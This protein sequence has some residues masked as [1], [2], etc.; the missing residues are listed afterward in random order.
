MNRFFYSLDNDELLYTKE[1]LEDVITQEDVSFVVNCNIND[2]KILE[3][4]EAFNKKIKGKASVAVLAINHEEDYIEDETQIERLIEIDDYCKQTN[5]KLRVHLKD[6]VGDVENLVIARNKIEEFTDKLKSFTYEKD[7]K[8]CSLTTLQKYFICY[9][10]VA[11]RVYNMSENYGDD[12]MR[13]WIGV[14][15]SDVVICSGFASLLKCVCDRVFEKD[16]LVCYR[17]GLDVYFKETG[18]LAGGHANNLI[19]I[20]DKQ[21][22]VSGLFTSDSCWG[23]KKE[24]NGMRVSYEHAFNPI[25]IYSKDK[26]YTF[27]FPAGLYFYELAEGVRLDSKRSCC[28]KSSLLQDIEKIT[29]AP[30]ILSLES[31]DAEK[32]VRKKYKEEREKK[33]EKIIEKN[34]QEFERIVEKYNL[35][36]VIKLFVPSSFPKNFIEKQPILAEYEKLFNIRSLK[37]L[38]ENVEKIKEFEQFYNSNQDLFTALMQKAKDAGIYNSIFSSFKNKLY[39]NCVETAG[40]EKYSSEKVEKL[41]EKAVRKAKQKALS[42]G[43]EFFVP[44]EL[45]KEALSCCFEGLARFGGVENQQDINSYINQEFERLEHLKEQQFELTGIDEKTK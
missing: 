28:Y 38:E 26:K 34:K 16:E 1:K 5:Q 20:N 6:A 21:L 41:T 36:N 11:N 15:S 25:T 37:E 3:K 30:E 27:E 42:L 18:E 4:F 31:W 13:N 14:L 22:G 33:N 17:Q 39:F 2:D 24:R 10:F 32:I 9:N 19:I 43:K 35:T 8:K 45:N 40:I 12:R 44:N 23:S 29:N 7:G